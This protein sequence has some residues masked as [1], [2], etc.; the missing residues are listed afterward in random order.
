MTAIPYYVMEEHHEAFFLWHYAIQR[1]LIPASGNFLLHVDEHAD[2]GTP[3][4]HRAL[5]EL[6]DD[7]RT[8][9]RF[10][11]DELSCFEFIVPALYQRLF[12]EWVWIQANPPRNSDQLLLVQGI[13]GKGSRF[14]LKAADFVEGRPPLVP[15]WW[16]ERASRYRLQTI[17]E[18]L[19]ANDPLV[20]DIDLDYFS[21][22]DAVNLVQKLE[23][24]RDEYESFSRDRYHFL[25]VNQGSR[26]KMQEEGGRF[27]LYLRNYPEP[28]PTPLRVSD[29]EILERIE[30]FA[31]WLEA[32][33]IR[34]RLIG[35]ARSRFSGYT[36][37]DQWQFIETH[38]IER[39]GRLYDL[40]VRSADDVRAE[41]A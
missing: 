19:E 2:L 8:I 29:D 32:N 22:E 17:A 34:P 14:E 39:L 20:L 26:I 33:R 9:D 11:F 38:L 5:D 21:C 7:L 40:D 27:F 1:E 31:A 41:I 18:P 35:S 30:R 3:R 15:L 28:M 36:P 23:V 16:H 12:A 25:R 13:G 4:L 24:T 37:L 6:G 10:T